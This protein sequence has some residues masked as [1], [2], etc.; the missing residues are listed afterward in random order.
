MF[1]LRFRFTIALNAL[2]LMS[3]S[4]F[5]ISAQEKI[6]YL[7]CGKLMD[8]NSAQVQ[9]EVTIIVKN[10]LID[11]IEKGYKQAPANATTID[12]KN[13]TVMPG[14]MDMHIHIESES[15]P[16]SY[17]ERF[18]LN[19]AD[20]AY[21]AQNFGL[22][23]LKAGFTTV[24]DLGGTGV[25][26]AYRNAINQ[27][28]VAGPR[29]FTAEKSIATTGGH[30]DPTNGG[31]RD[32]FED[33]GPDLGVINSPEEGRKAVRQ[34]YKNGAD[35]IKITATGGVLSVAA[36]GLNPQ[37]F[38]DELEAIIQTAKDY[39]FHTAAH[40]H[41][42]EGMKRAVMAGIT[43]IEH[44]TYMTEEIMELMKEK[45]TYYVPTI[46]AGQ[47]VGQK[48]KIAG[49]YPRVVALKAA[50]IGP[51]IQSTFAKAYK[52]GVKIAFG[53]DSGVSL[54][55]DNADEFVLMVEAGM[56]PHEAIKSATVTTA[57]LLNLSDKVGTIT[58]GKWADIVA[59]EGD[60]L[61]N[62]AILKNVKFVM[63]DGE[64]Y[65]NE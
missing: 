30:A 21:R 6:T 62:I 46:S 13:K 27:G 42:T 19:E 24:R 1:H 3:L 28:L 55:G 60:P 53:T 11:K 25:N 14:F 63:K 18:T 50:A 39:G 56:P 10:N 33:P 64:V 37:F 45:G 36:S 40:A 34:R 65:K 58:V 12:L 31:S 29:I 61:Q 5:P 52:A 17:L 59:V 22:K 23:T 20:K 15:N 9:S 57:Q 54:H 16:N 2:I 38:E 4:A 35:L 49:F 7:H 8:M 47:F 43:S 44:G 51:Q 32:L 48:A 26:V 41:G